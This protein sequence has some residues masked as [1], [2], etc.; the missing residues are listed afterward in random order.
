MLVDS[1][2]FIAKDKIPENN[3]QN[4]LNDQK[5]AELFTLIKWNT[6]AWIILL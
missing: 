6:I 4:I 2:L 1:Y 3:L 5:L